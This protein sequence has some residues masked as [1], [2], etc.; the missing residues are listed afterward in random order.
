MKVVWNVLFSRFQRRVSWRKLQWFF[1]FALPWTLRWRWRE[2]RVVCQCRGR[3]SRQLRFP[4]S[5]RRGRVENVPLLEIAVVDKPGSP[6]VRPGKQSELTSPIT[7]RV[8]MPRVRIVVIMIWHMV[9]LRWGQ[10]L[11]SWRRG[12]DRRDG[13]RWPCFANRLADVGQSTAWA[14]RVG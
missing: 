3:K 11:R 5:R 1:L 14:L 8:P 10:W 12:R 7:S 9:R 6:E 13:S 2:W 4:A